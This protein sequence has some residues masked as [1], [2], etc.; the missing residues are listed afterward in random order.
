MLRKWCRGGHTTHTHTQEKNKNDTGL[1]NGVIYSIRRDDAVEIIFNSICYSG[2]RGNSVL[3]SN[4]ELDTGAR[5]LSQ[6]LKAAYIP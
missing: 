1:T 2:Q 5:I 6:V 4:N 3:C